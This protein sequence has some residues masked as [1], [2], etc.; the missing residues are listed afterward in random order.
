[1]IVTYIFIN[2]VDIDKSVRRENM[3]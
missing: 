1:M 3:N 2:Q